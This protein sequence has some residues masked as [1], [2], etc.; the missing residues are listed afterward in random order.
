[1]QLHYHRTFDFS[2]FNGERKKNCMPNFTSLVYSV[3]WKT[4]NYHHLVF[5][6][7]LWRVNLS[8]SLGLCGLS[9]RR[10]TESVCECVQ[11]APSL[12][13]SQYRRETF[14]FS[15]LNASHMASFNDIHIQPAHIHTRAY[16]L[17]HLRQ[18]RTGCAVYTGVNR[19]EFLI[20]LVPLGTIQR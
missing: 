1:M 7:W 9:D 16:M 5:W 12:L 20:E 4:S 18:L 2:R 17:G 15:L 6:I 10:E 11:M 14:S 13:S 19:K 3:D 8:C